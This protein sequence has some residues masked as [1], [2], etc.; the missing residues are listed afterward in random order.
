MILKQHTDKP[1]RTWETPYRWPA[2]L[3]PRNFERVIVEVGPG[4]GDFLYHLAEKHGDALVCAIEIKRKR[5]DRL[6]HRLQKRGIENVML[7]QNDARAALPQC[8][9]KASID[10]IHINFPDPW[11]KKRHTKNRLMCESFLKEC[12]TRLKPGGHFNFATDQ[13]WY[14]FETHELFAR[15]DA[16]ESV[17]DEGVVINPPDAF[18]TLFMQKWKDNGRTLHYQRY[19]KV[20]SVGV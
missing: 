3:D 6:V 11:P 16:L 5:I 10:E 20:Q 14:A 7:I 15:V 2:S 1:L 12:A 13:D 8:F 18:P 19:I 17:Y 4:R 9:E